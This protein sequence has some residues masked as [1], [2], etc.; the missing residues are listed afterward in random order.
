MSTISA[1][2]RAA[3][4]K[5]DTQKAKKV[6]RYFLPP[7]EDQLFFWDSCESEYDSWIRTYTGCDT[8]VIMGP[9]GLKK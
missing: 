1:N 2:K 9:F 8:R 6:T 4:E 5:D 3:S 7:F